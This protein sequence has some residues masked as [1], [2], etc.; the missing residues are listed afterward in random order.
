MVLDELIHPT[1]AMLA[2][3]L[4]VSGNTIVAYTKKGMPVLETGTKGKPHKYNF[5]DCFLWV[6]AHGGLVKRRKA[7]MG[8]LPMVLLG[9]AIVAAD[10]GIS[11]YARWRPR[12]VTLA[13]RLGYSVEEFD[14]ALGK[15]IEGEFLTMIWSH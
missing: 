6:V 4:G 10:D 7:V 12:G 11:C 2:S 1:G 9:D 3:M 5:P 15:L 8:T 14:F 13:E